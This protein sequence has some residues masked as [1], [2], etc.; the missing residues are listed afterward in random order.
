MQIDSSYYDAG[1]ML[2]TVNGTNA[3]SGGGNRSL[4]LTPY[5][6]CVTVQ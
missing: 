4:V 3:S 1:T 6:V 2:W 5:A